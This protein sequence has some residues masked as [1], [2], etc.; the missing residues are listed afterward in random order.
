MMREYQVRFCER[1]G[2]K[3]PGPTR[4]LFPVHGEVV[5]L[6]GN[7]AARGLV[8]WRH[9]ATVHLDDPP[10]H[11]GRPRAAADDQLMF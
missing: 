8:S 6:R 2:V 3:F 7:R 5:N 9:R 10:A 11:I 4:P 1:L